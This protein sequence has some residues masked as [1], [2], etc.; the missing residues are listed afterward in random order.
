MKKRALAG[1]R[2]IVNN[3]RMRSLYLPPELAGG[4]FARAP[5]RPRRSTRRLRPACSGLCRA[6]NCEYCL[7]HQELK[8]SV[9][10]MT[11]DQLAA[12]DVDWAAYPA[13][14][15]AAF[16]F[17]RRL[18]YLPHTLDDAAIDKLRQHYKDRQILEI[19]FTVAG[20]NATN[21][22]TD[23]LGIP[24]DS[25]GSFFARNNPKAPK[26]DY[27]TFL[28]PTADAFKDRPSRVAPLG[29]I[30]GRR[31]D[32][33]RRARPN[34]RQ[35]KAAKSRGGAGEVSSSALRVSR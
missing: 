4:G 17:T 26:K 24:E 20:N 6:N 31:D 28:S 12:L 9:A 33:R 11:D 10:G 35:W 18:T 14:E 13:E 19:I 16:E 7:G 23:S 34:D 30:D 32:R 21:R 1:D 5:T 29:H 8:L 25:D 2:H 27:S 22:W 15:Q 3:G